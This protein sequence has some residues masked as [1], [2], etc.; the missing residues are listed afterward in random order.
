MLHGV[1]MLANPGVQP[2]IATRP[3]PIPRVRA[4]CLAQ[5]KEARFCPSADRISGDTL[6]RRSNAGAPVDCGQPVGLRLGARSTRLSSAP[7]SRPRSVARL[8]EFRIH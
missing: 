3:V 5:I 2:T 1:V 4:W 6:T 7:A 8:V